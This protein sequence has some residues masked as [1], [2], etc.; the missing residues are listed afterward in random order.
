[1]DI[2]AGQMLRGREEQLAEAQSLAHLGSWEW[3]IPTD[4]VTWSDELYRIFGLQPQQF[5]TTH[6]AFLAFVHP[7]DREMIKR[8]VERAYH[9]GSPFNFEYRILR[10]DGTARWLH[11]LG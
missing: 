7:D 5:G 9:E 8:E 2:T 6:E 4:T 1:M 3:H 11:G 10:P